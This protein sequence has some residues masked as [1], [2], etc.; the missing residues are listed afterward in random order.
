[1]RDGAPVDN[2]TM[3]DRI[4]RNSAVQMAR[5]KQLVEAAAASTGP[6]GEGR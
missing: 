5:I 3:T 4:N 6:D 1:M 2:A